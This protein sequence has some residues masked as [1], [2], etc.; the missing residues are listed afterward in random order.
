[1]AWITISIDTVDRELLKQIRRKVDLRTI[2]YNMQAIRLR[3]A[4]C[5]WREPVCYGREPVF[6]WQC[7]G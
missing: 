3:A 2:L 1:M 7:T 5:Y 4:N 6:N